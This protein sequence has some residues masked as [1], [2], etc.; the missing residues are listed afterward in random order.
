MKNISLDPGIYTNI[1][2]VFVPNERVTVMVA[3]ESAFP[4]LHE[5]RMEIE[6]SGWRA[7]VYQYGAQVFGY[8]QDM[9]QLASMGFQREKIRLL[10]YPGWCAR[11]IAEGLSDYLK[12]RGYRECFGKGRKQLYEP[13]PYRTAAREQLQVFRGYDL[14]VL[15][16][17]R[18]DQ[19]IFGLI[20]DICWEIQNRE[21][22]RLNT[23]EIAQYRAMAEIAQIQEE[24]LSDN[25][26]NPEVSRSRLLNHILPFVRS[27]KEFRLPICENLN[28]QLEQTPLRVVVGVQ[29]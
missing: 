10:E 5:I 11:L 16:V 17:W 27:C 21:G 8:G 29:Q 3:P 23:T 9:E 4:S 24:Y 14:R 22:K 25:R 28:V 6:Q 19:P 12:D 7:R 18:E 1:F 13:N 15:Y 2:R 20:V 26:I